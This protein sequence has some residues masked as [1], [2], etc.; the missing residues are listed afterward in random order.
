MEGDNISYVS[1]SEKNVFEYFCRQEK[2]QTRK[3]QFGE[4]EK[5]VSKFYGIERN[6]K[7]MS[8]FK[9]TWTIYLRLR[10]KRRNKKVYNA[11]EILEQA[12]VIPVQFEKV[13][14]IP[15]QDNQEEATSSK[16]RK[17]N[18]IDLSDKMKKERINELISIL[19][20]YVRVESPELSTTQL[21]GFDF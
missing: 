18:F 6:N 4:S 11:Q 7:W 9:K 1:L 21:L 14:E 10:T 12:S 3:L 20:N 17:K 8:F 19:N 13:L 16:K 15:E 5:A 2:F